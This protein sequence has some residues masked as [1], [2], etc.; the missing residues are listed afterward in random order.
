M[1]STTANMELNDNQAQKNVLISIDFQFEEAI[2]MYIDH[3]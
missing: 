2:I 1:N 3:S